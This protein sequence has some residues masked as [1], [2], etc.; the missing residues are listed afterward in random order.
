[1]RLTTEVWAKFESKGRPNETR[2]VNNQVGLVAKELLGWLVEV[3]MGHYIRVTIARTESEL[4]QHSQMGGKS[5]DQIRDSLL[6]DFEKALE[7]LGFNSTPPSPDAI[8]KHCGDS[9][10]QHD[11]RGDNFYCITDQSQLFESLD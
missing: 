1:M 10:S 8:C 11:Q 4:E 5:K 7:E 9:W 2:V 6:G 3:P